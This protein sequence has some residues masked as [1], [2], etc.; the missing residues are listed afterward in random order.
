VEVMGLEPTTSTLRTWRSTGLS[1]TPEGGRTLARVEGAPLDGGLQA[2]LEEGG[3]EIAT[4]PLEH[5]A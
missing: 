4:S 2:H 1:Y 3:G 5:G